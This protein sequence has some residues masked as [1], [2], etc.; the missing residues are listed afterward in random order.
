MSFVPNSNYRVLK[1]TAVHEKDGHD[2]EHYYIEQKLSIGPNNEQQHYQVSEP[3]QAL[4][5]MV[6]GGKYY[7]VR[8][9][10]Q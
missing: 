10:L 8:I 5:P 6:R 7:I 3:R 1:V 9:P 4:S 2:I